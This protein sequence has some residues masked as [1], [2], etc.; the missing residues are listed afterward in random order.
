[1]AIG[2]LVYILLE[3]AFVGAVPSQNIAQGWA[4]PLGQGSNV[5]GPYY[6]LAVG[7]GISWLS[8]VLIIDAVISPG[9]TGLIYVGTSSRISYALGMPS[10]MR[11]T[12]KRGV[13]LWSVLVAWHR[14]RAGSSSSA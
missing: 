13:P 9:G 8:V 7:A 11:R 14:R 4:H 5:Y 2:A 6:T 1:M 10:W 12:T 3:V